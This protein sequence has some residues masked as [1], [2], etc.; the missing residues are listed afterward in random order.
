MT[1]KYIGAYGFTEVIQENNH[2]F[3]CHGG[4]MG[5]TE[6]HVREN[7]D[8][9]SFSGAYDLLK[10]HRFARTWGSA[11]YAFTLRVPNKVFKEIVGTL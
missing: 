9:M 10:A 2:T 4:N 3:V 8:A 6:K 1:E 11:D 7:F 5:N